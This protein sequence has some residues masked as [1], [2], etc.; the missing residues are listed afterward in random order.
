MKRPKT[1]WPTAAFLILL[2][3]AGTTRFRGLAWGLPHTYHVDENWFAGKAMQFFG[4]DLN[5]R[6]FHV[7]TLH[8]Y[9][10]AGLWRSYYLAGRTVGA[11][12]SPA[13]FEAAFARDPTVFYLIG[14]SLSALL[15]IGTI[16]LLYLIGTRM[17]GRRAGFLAALLLVFALDHNRIS[18]D[19]L[20]DVPMV[21][22][23]V[24]SFWFIWKIR[25]GGRTR[26][27]LL[28]GLAAGIAMAMKY[29][30]QMMLLP[31]F[32]A[33]LFRVLESGRPRREIFLSP[34]LIGA[35]LVFAAAFLA[36]SPYIVLDFPKFWSEF[37]WQTRHLVTEGHYGSSLEESGWGFYFAY[38][39]REN[40]GLLS[41]FLVLGGL[42]L[43]LLRR[44]RRDLILLSFPL[45]LFLLIAG[46]KT[47]ATRYLMPLAPF[48][49]LVGGVFLDACFVWLGRAAGRLRRRTARFA[50]GAAG[51]LAAALLLYSSA[52]EVF[53]MNEAL[54]A[55]DSRTMARDWIQQHI[56]P[57]TTIAM[58]SYGPPISRDR[59]TVILRHSLSDVDLEWLSLR[60][61]E[62]VLISDIMADRFT[63]YPREF[64]RENAFYRSLA[65]EAV[66][67]KT[68]R[69]RYRGP[70]LE[71]HFPTIRIYRLSRA[72][73]Y[74]FP[75]NFG[76]Y[77]QSVL[78]ERVN[79][80][81][82]VRSAVAASSLFET[83]EKPSNPYL[84]LTDAEGREIGRF[85][86]HDG[87]FRTEG[88]F[89]GQGG[90]TIASLPEGSRLHLGYEYA[91]RPNPLSAPA[92]GVFRKEAPL[93]EIVDRSSIEAGRW[94]C[95]YVFVRFPGRRGDDYFQDVALTRRGEAADLRSRVFG[96]GLRYR[97]DFVRNPFVLLRGADGEDLKKIV[98][99]PGKLGSLDADAFAPAGIEEALPAPPSGFRILVGYDYYFNNFNP[100][101]A[102]GP[103]IIEIPLP[104]LPGAPE[105]R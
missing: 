99:F 90:G 63:A 77:A 87:E 101:S 9:M 45:V 12:R 27:Y 33:H 34:K 42:V 43:A 46:W 65:H 85:R 16:L 40:V 7:P 69:P 74:G 95:D 57:G 97:E 81:W 76:R 22:F 80:E 103:E 41:Q 62:Y 10:I 19:M 68:V 31:L 48:F 58:E 92:E 26:D 96:G 3:L 64:P 38:G 52:R 30:G 73:H 61:V 39:F 56:V 25:T 2:V 94:A 21:F 35:G 71:I 104:G 13:D 89:L 84:R 17:Y 28:A 53:R 44:R 37:R 1:V 23:L 54:A 72:P 60:K 6:F 82:R 50:A 98:V 70:L 8:M 11:F 79:G 55:R 4:G 105:K 83:K 5:P 93:P 32:L 14:R 36:G 15:S 47:R 91:L 78:L 24:L 20:P 86:L 29:G 49:I 18:H 66:L 59:Y 100:G 102:G 88:A 67:I 51:V 75:G